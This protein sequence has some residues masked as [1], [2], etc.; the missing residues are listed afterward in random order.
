[1]AETVKGKT[2]EPEFAAFVGIDWADQKHCW[3]L[4]VAGTQA[5]ESGEL[6]HTPEELSQ[7]VAALHHR[8]GGRSVA[9]ALEQSCGALVYQL[10]QYPHLWLYPVHPATAAHYRRAF[11]PSGSKS[12]PADTGLL[13]ELVVHHRDRLRPLVPETPATRLLRMLV[14]QRRQLVAEKTRWNNRLKAALK[15]YFPQVLNWVDIDTTMGCDLLERWPM[16]QQLQSAHPGT[17]RKFFREHNCRSESL[18]TER[19][20]AIYQ[21]TPAVQDAALLEGQVAVAASCIAQIRVLLA[22][23][24][25]LDHQI[26]GLASQHPEASLFSALPGAGAALQPRLIAAFGTQR[27]RYADARELQAYSGIA[28]VTESSGHSRWVHV[29]WSC[30]QFLRQTFHEFAACSISR[31]EWARVFYEA[32]IAAGKSHH[33]AVRALAYK[34][35]RVL[36][37]CW[38]DC[39]PY[40]ERTYLLALAKRNSPLQWGAGSSTKLVW[41]T[42]GGF[43]KLSTE[44][45]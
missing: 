20:Q 29:R 37:R 3:K 26:E 36:F 24:A 9:V 34:W 23:I 27:D 16:L 17:L 32:K 44:S 42:V 21:A 31:W 41:K 18:I 43:K 8:F 45:S 30:P 22:S 15:M 7:W 6:K 28:P 14:E 10:S 12:D 2:S 11:Y 35:I 38:K 39:R 4:M 25:K 40:D 13:L 19:I 1:M 33:A 5:S